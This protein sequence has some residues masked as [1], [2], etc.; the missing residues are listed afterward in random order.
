M[1]DTIHIK[2]SHEG[3][4]TEKAKRHNMGVQEF[5]TYVLSHKNEFDIATI[6]QANFAKNF[7]GG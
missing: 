7:G 3:L 1:V 2:P 6:K 4:F 5:A